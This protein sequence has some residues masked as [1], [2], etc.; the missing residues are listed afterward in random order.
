C[1]PSRASV[2]TGLRP[3]TTKVLGNGDDYDDFA[4]DDL[5]FIAGVLKQKGAHTAQTGK[6]MHKWKYAFKVIDQFDQVEMEKPFASDSGVIIDLE[7]DRGPFSGIQKYRSGL[8]PDII[9]PIPDKNWVWVPHP[10]HDSALQ[11]L[12][13]EKMDRLAAGEE[14]TWTLRKPF[15]QYHA[16]MLGDAGFLETH[17]DDGVVTRLGV[18]MIEDFAKE[19]KQFFLNVG[20]YAPHTPLLAPKKYMDLFDTSK[21]EISTATRDKDVNVPGIAVRN[22]RNY[23]LFNGYYPQFSPTPARQKLAIASHY[24]C[25]AMIDDQVGMLLKAIEDNGIA[26]NTIV[27]LWAD[28]GFHL[29]EHGCWSKFTIFEQSTHVPLVVYVPGAKGNGKSCNQLVELVDMLPTMCDMWGIEKDQR[30]EGLSFVD[31]LENPDQEWKKAAYSMV[32]KP[33][34]G[35]SV[36][37]KKYRFGEYQD[38]RNEKNVPA[39]TIMVYEL[40]DLEKDPFEQHNLAGEAEYAEILA[41]HKRLLHEGWKSALPDKYK[42]KRN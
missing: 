33:I 39:D 16:E 22:G 3:E 30:F 24:A 12:Y 7:P 6:L 37:T 27:I 32:P 10:V 20:L 19:G 31:L 41:E 13:K 21:I 34:R 15:Q 9:Q 18:K 2:T 29:G 23:D 28:H 40:Y 4:P 11:S 1:N 26:E 14:N 38:V 17:T 8:I 42:K 25:G 36:S 35:R 5:P